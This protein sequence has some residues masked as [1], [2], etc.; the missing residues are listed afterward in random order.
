LTAARRRA[1]LALLIGAIWLAPVAA[2]RAEEPHGFKVKGTIVAMNPASLAGLG[3]TEFVAGCDD[4]SELQGLDG[5]WIRLPAD[6]GGHPAK[7]VPADVTSD[8]DAFFYTDSC[9]AL[10]YDEMASGIS[11][12][13]ETG[14]VPARAAWVVVDLFTGVAA[15]FTFTVEGVH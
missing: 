12:E 4:G 6:A 14:D 10:S 7:L 11:G 15:S 2:S 1:A 5:Y 3:L 9:D 8:V 13:I